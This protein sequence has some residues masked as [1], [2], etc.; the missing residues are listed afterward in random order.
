MIKLVKGPRQSGRTTLLI[1]KAATHGHATIVVPTQTMAQQIKFMI[2]EMIKADEMSNVP[3]KVVS[4]REF[5]DNNKRRGLSENERDRDRHVYFDDV[6][7]CLAF[8]CNSTDTV[9]LGT[10]DSD[11]IED[12]KDFEKS[13]K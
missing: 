3:I 1:K 5:I 4:I 7:M 12:I 13:E 9:H 8:L 6:E 2:N 10:I 11:R